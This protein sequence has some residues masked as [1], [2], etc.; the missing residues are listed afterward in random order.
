MKK[1]RKIVWDKNKDRLNRKDHGIP[2]ETAKKVFNDPMH[3]E[4]YDLK[5]SSFEDRWNIYGLVGDTVFRVTYTE[6]GDVTRIISAR[7]AED[8]EIEEYFY[9]YDK[10]YR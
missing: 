8:N 1:E 2:F 6:K 7:K 10:N 3:I 9:G 4:D 5:H